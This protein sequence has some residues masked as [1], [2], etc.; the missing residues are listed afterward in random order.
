[1]KIFFSKSTGGF[2]LDVLH[3]NIPDDAV[4]ITHDFYSELIEK[5]S[6]GA[7]ITSN[8]KGYPVLNKWRI[9]QYH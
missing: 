7:T 5:Q 8:K 1:M 4:E 3:K 6:L 9:R 2:Y